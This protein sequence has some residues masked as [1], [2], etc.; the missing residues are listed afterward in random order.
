MRLYLMKNKKSIRLIGVDLDGTLLNDD[1]QLCD[2]ARE[3]ISAAKARGIHLVPITGRPLTGIPDCIRQVPEIEYYICSNGAQIVDAAT[4]ESLYSYTI[5]NA[6]CRKIIS[7]LRTLDCKFEP[8]AD[9]VGYA[10]PDVYN[11][12]KETFENTPLAD[13]IFSSRKVA[14]NL[15]ALFADGTRCADEFFVNCSDEAT[16][17]ALIRLMD[18]IGGLQYCNLGDRFIEI[19]NKGTDKGE[20]LEALCRHL[21]IAV[22]NTMAFGDGENDLLFLEK[23]GIAVAMGNAFPSV[24][25]KADIIADTNNDNG[26]CKI[27]QQL[28]F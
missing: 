1:K 3:T 18:G 2:G 10:E 24:K 21:G 15:E 25:E 19:T 28:L 6:R 11:Y 22:E 23:A 9:G 17:T 5:D 16:R 20:A 13:Y 27:I 14:E 26:V 4:G 8:F 7:A 12:Y